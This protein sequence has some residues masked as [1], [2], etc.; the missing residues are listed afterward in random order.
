MIRSAE[1]LRF[2]GTTLPVPSTTRQI[3]RNDGSACA[4]HNK[5]L[6]TMLRT[7]ARFAKYF[8]VVMKIGRRTHMNLSN[9]TRIT[10]GLPSIASGHALECDGVAAREMTRIVHTAWVLSGSL[11][12]KLHRNSTQRA[13]AQQP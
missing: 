9:P 6:G 2:V 12:L 4:Q 8:V 5:G 11:P 3:V 13:S 10:Y 7:C 1:R